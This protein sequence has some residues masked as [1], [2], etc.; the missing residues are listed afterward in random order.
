MP[1]DNNASVS[2]IAVLLQ[3][4]EESSSDPSFVK[5][6]SQW[7]DALIE[8]NK[9]TR[10]PCISFA[11]PFAN[12]FDESFLNISYFVIVDKL[13][14]P[15]HP[16]FEEFIKKN[17]LGGITYRDTYFLLDENKDDLQYHFHELV[18]VLQWNILGDESF[19]LKYFQE[20]KKHGYEN[21][22]IEKV[23]LELVNLFAQKE[24]VNNLAYYVESRLRLST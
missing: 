17:N 15:E 7:I 3:S 14:S 5:D 2:S 11:S 10:T 12:Y 18:H 13:P 23:A 22:P 8:E 1:P 6:I 16:L 19:I 21:S 9:S 24:E 4:I 20:I